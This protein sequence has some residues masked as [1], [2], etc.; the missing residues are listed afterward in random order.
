[1]V[2]GIKK[3]VVSVVAV[4]I[5][6]TGVASASNG[7]AACKYGVV[8]ERAKNSQVYTSRCRSWWEYQ[9]AQAAAAASAAAA[10]LNKKIDVQAEYSKQMQGS[11]TAKAACAYY[12]NCR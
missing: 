6:S 2:K 1:M 12:G 4:A 10:K 5:L 8:Y 9:A 7:I 3:L 11:T